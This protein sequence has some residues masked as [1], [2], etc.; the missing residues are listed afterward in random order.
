MN[1]RDERSEELRKNLYEVENW[2]DK[3]EQAVQTSSDIDIKMR[4]LQ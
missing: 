4:Q 2:K 1:E 3:Y